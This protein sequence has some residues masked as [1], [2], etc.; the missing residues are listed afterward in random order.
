MSN[1]DKLEQYPRCGLDWDENEIEKQQ[2]GLCLWP[3]PEPRDLLDI[4]DE[5]EDEL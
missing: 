5:E 4:T 1:E 2:C 3:E